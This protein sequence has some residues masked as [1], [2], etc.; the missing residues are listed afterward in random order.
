MVTLRYHYVLPWLHSV[1]CMVLFRGILRQ[2]VRFYVW[3]HLDPLHDAYIFIFSGW[4]FLFGPD[5]SENSVRATFHRT[6][7]NK[8][9]IAK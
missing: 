3:I 2:P 7:T 9:K 1:M 8:K 6:S 4:I 5:S